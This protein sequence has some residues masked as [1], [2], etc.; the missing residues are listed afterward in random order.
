MLPALYHRYGIDQVRAALKRAPATSG[1]RGRAFSYL[2]SVL[3]SNRRNRT[4]KTPGH[5]AAVDSYTRHFRNLVRKSSTP[6]H[7]PAPKCHIVAK[8]HAPTPFAFPSSPHISQATLKVGT[9]PARDSPSPIQEEL[10]SS[11][12]CPEVAK[13]DKPPTSPQVRGL[14]GAVSHYSHSMVAGGFE[15]MS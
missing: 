2:F 6:L 4:H 3:P 7:Y 5:G 15:V 1:Q 10:M 13:K 11:K 9:M 8:C 12:G 14:N